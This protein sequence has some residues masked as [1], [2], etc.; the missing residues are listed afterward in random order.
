M[1]FSIQKT[2]F[3]VFS[4]KSISSRVTAEEQ[5]KR[6]YVVATAFIAIPFLLGFGLGHL[7]TGGGIENS[8]PDLLAAG[9]FIATLWFLRTDVD[10]RVAYRTLMAGF[11]FLLF[12]NVAVGLY[13]GSDILWLYI[14]PLVSFFLFGIVE[15][16]VWNG[17]FLGPVFVVI[18]FPG[19][20]NSYPF[21][22]EYQVRLV[23]SLSVVTLM[24]WLLES[25]RAYF[26]EQLQEQKLALESALRDIKTLR[27]L[28]PICATCKK[29]RDDKGYWQAVESYI[30]SHTEAQFSHGICEACLEKT[31]PEIYRILVA[32]GKLPGK[33]Q[34][35]PAGS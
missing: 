30:S 3:N 22:S 4:P 11:S 32:K 31:E 28:I 12:F 24:A 9:L 21:P 26:Y 2:I 17:L 25:L 13:Q 7:F 6:V 33:K 29:I 35:P 19:L 18:L 1:H 15:G 10:G 34:T 23:L 27:G 8:V 14:Y 20:L 16:F 5:R